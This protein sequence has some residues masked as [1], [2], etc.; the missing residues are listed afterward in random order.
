MYVQTSIENKGDRGDHLNLMAKTRQRIGETELEIIDLKNK[1]LNQVVSGLR[2]TQAE[3]LDVRERLKAAEDILV[4][5]DIRAPQ[6]G[7]VMGLNVH[8]E[9]GVISPGQHLLDI[10]PEDDTLVIEAQVTPNDIDVVHVGLPAQVRLTAFK[11]RDTP[12]LDGK[13]TR[14]SADSFTDER[15]G[16]SYFLAR[17]AIDTAEISKLD[18]RELYPG[19]GA[20]VM[21][22]TGK[23]TTMD[24]I[25]A[26]LTDSLRR[27][28]RED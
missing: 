20:E 5:T 22:K 18:G 28:F 6:A 9:M 8:T 15:S 25:L 19:M 12:L 13:L 10:V 17:V 11:Q 21:I 2:D 1:V 3:L 14:I 7:V 16:A 27:A 23:R 26:P 4:R 24:Y